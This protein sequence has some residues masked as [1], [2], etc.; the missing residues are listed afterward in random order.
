M[1]WNFNT[2]IIYKS[3]LLHL[4]LRLQHT[5][6]PRCSSCLLKLRLWW[7]KEY[8]SGYQHFTLLTICHL[9][10]AIYYYVHYH[11]W[12]YT[13]SMQTFFVD[14]TWVSPR[15]HVVLE[16]PPWPL[17]VTFVD[18]AFTGNLGFHTVCFHGDLYDIKPF[19][20][21]NTI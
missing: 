19:A 6:G 4:A 18:V 2:T 7:A 11:L 14:S 15:C 1:F 20:I 16:Y 9:S 5:C 8:H 13:V 21:S 17:V 3:L 10:A 12:T